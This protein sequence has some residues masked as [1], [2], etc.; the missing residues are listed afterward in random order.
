MGVF[1]IFRTRG[2]DWDQVIEMDL[3]EDVRSD[4]AL[5]RH[6]IETCINMI[7]KTV[8]QSEFQ[9]R[10]GGHLEQD[11]MYYRLNV[12]PNRNMS[13][14]HFW[15]TV[16]RKMV[17]DN[18]C[19]IIKTDDDEL[20]IADDF[21]RKDL[22]L[23]DDTFSNVRVGDITFRRTFEMQEVVYLPYSNDRMTAI[24]DGLFKSYGELFSRVMEY[25]YRKGQ[26]RSVVHMEGLNPKDEEGKARLQ[27][28]IESVYRTTSKAIHAVFPSQKGMEY[29]EYTST[30]QPNVDEVG[31]VA[32]GFMEHVAR[33]LGIPVALLRG[34]MADIEKQKENYMAFCINP[35]LDRISDELN[36]KFISKREYLSGDRINIRSVATMDIFA[37][38]GNIDKLISSTAFTGNEIRER[39]GEERSDDPLMDK[40]LITK[41]YQL[42]EEATVSTSS[43]SEGGEKG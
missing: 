5:K 18:E 37:I 7:G 27:K 29:K 41:N 25:Q 17:L 24:V 39:L 26:I 23:F 38:A 6:A 4:V 14:H 22:T 35:L 8:S 2:I 10:I 3:F 20:L 15:Q 43:S 33:A 42:L 11:E 40:H 9:T 1:D 30:Y 28:F 19:L 34:E 21:D 13:A 31:K 32:N 36:G 16:V 12:R